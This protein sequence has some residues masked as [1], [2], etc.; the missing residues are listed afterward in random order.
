MCL[1]R[2]KGNYYQHCLCQF[3]KKDLILE[4]E[5]TTLIT[6]RGECPDERWECDE[7]KPPDTSKNAL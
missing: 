5:E 3:F 2:H 6:M 4:E 1:Q 7:E